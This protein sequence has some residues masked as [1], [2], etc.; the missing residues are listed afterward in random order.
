M[1]R[2]INLIEGIYNHC[3][4]WC[5]RCLFTSRCRSFQIQSEAGLIG[6]A[7]T[8]G[9]M[10][11]QL[12][13]ALSLTKQYIDRLNHAQKPTGADAPDDSQTQ[14]LEENAVQRDI[15]RRDL[16]TMLANQYLRQTGMWL[17]N[18]KH[19]LKQTGQQQ[20]REVELGLRTE[21]EAM[22]VLH[23]LKDAWEMIQWYRTLIPVKIQSALRALSDPTDD[24]HLTVYHLGKA[25][26]VLVSIDR[27]L[28]AWQTILQCFPEKTDDL[29]SLLVL[30]TRL[31]R[32][33][34]I[35]FPNAQAFQRPGLD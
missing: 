29:L 27:S 20:I 8:G 5:E 35:L 21:Q 3:D 22:P 10:V 34:D 32:E 30:L 1:N 12:T 23:A 24:A 7:D 9:D 14:F 26:L 28:L 16:V 25:K 31:R 4:T 2:H 17:T 13:D 19:L 6:S 15:S 11:Q 33:M 18:E